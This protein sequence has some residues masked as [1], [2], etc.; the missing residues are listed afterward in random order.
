MRK[1]HVM[2]SYLYSTLETGVELSHMEKCLDQAMLEKTMHEDKMSG[3]C[4]V[5]D[6]S[7]KLQQLECTQAMLSWLD[8]LMAKVPTMEFYNELCF[9]LKL[10]VDPEVQQG[11]ALG[12]CRGGGCCRGGGGGGGGR[13]C[14]DRG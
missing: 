11:W 12:T 1:N 3:E 4:N 13:P 7:H 2:N 10:E 8:I 9:M 6:R 14:A 5:V